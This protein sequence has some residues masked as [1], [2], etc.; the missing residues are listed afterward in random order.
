MDD[1]LRQQAEALVRAD[2][3]KDEFLAV[4]AHELRNPLAPIAYALDLLDEKS[5]S[6]PPASNPPHR[7]PPGGRLV[8]ADRRPAG[9][10]P[11]PHRQDRARRSQVALSDAV[12]HTVEV[13]PA[14]LRGARATR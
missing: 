4:L 12:G 1:E 2:Q 11:H 13:D 7:P 6:D 5:L 9:R 3:E 10:Q 8:A 14:D